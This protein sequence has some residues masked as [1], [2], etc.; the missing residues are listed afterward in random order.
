M[1]EAVAGR[2]RLWLA[3]CGCGWPSEAVAGRVRLWLA[4]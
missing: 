4:E 3:E 1:S 2:V